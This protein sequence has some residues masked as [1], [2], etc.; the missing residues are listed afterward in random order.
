MTPGLVRV[1][2]WLT[3]ADFGFLVAVLAPQLSIQSQGMVP[4]DLR[5]MGYDLAA[6]QAYLA[7]LTEAGRKLYLGPIRVTDTN[8]L[9]VARVM[10]CHEPENG[11][12]NVKKPCTIQHSRNAKAN[13]GPK[14]MGASRGPRRRIA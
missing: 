9:L 12:D 8:G 4:F 6:A 3:L 7:V 14:A 1:L 2:T 13:M 5:A 10:H 11:E